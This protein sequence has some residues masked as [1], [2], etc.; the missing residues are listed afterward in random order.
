M[1]SDFVCQPQEPSKQ[2][3]TQTNVFN[4][5]WLKICRKSSKLK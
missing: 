5:Q 3:E 2:L 4:Y 1:T